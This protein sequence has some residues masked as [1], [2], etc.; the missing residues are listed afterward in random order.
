MKKGFFVLGNQLFAKEYLPVDTDTPV[1]MAEDLGL[2]TYVKHHKQKIALFLSAMRSYADELQ[3]GGFMVCYKSFDLEEKPS[4]KESFVEGLLRFIKKHK[5]TELHFFEIED[6]A[7]EEVIKAAL[8]RSEVNLIEHP[9]PMFLTS[10]DDFG[11]F[12]SKYKPFMARFYEWQRKRLKVLVD[13]NGKPVGGKWSFDT[14]NRKRLPKKITLP[15]EPWSSAT[16][17]TQALIPWVNQHF[18]EH[19]GV[20]SEEGWWLPTERRHAKQWL[21]DFLEQRFHSFGDYEDAI[22]QRGVVLFH[23]ALTPSL[24]M[25]LLTPQEV[26]EAA[27]TYADAN[28]VNLNSLEGFIRQVIGWREFIHGVDRNFGSQQEASNF[29][30]HERILGSQWHD[31]TT[32]IPVL[33][34]T[35]ER[36]D[37]YGW[38]HHIE[39]LM[40]LGN[41]MLL[42]EIDPRDAYR[43]FMEYFVDSSDWVMG[44]NVYGMAL[45]SDGGIFATKPYIS[46]SNYLIKMS[47][48]PKGP[49]CDIVDG[50]YWRFVEKKQQYL[51]SNPRLSLMLGSL[52]KMDPARKQ[53]IFEAAE[54]F[55]EETTQKP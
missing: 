48:Y 9:S 43:Y 37:K 54:T 34:D 5:I 51:K 50:L 16:R 29:F 13:A 2:C 27:L 32:G 15:E 7:F 35:I 47:D 24:N 10:R 36:L 49:W 45:F 17:H 46:G 11:A 8:K 53:R 41:L 38:C 23:S 44:P 3:G 31:G 1:F 21:E 20:L 14:E 25:G 12:L 40:V 30:G 6:R 18:P 22:S 26:V 4:T 33:D 52:R 55:I 42:C 19:P 39:R 28:S